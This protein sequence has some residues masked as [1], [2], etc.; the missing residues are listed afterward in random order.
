MMI[1]INAIS[2]GMMIAIASYIYL[3]VGGM[4]GAFLFS[5]GLLT[6]L[7]M[8]F[9]LYTGAIGFIH[10]DPA[11]MQNITTILAGNLIGVCLL[12]FFPHSAAIPLVATKLVLP[13]GLVMIKQ[14]DQVSPS[15]QYEGAVNYTQFGEG[16][17]GTIYYEDGVAKIKDKAGEVYNANSP[18]V[19]NI[20]DVDGNTI[21]LQK[22]NERLT[23]ITKQAFDEI[24]RAHV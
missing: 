6:I 24:G 10:L 14:E 2:G 9:K 3:Q 21:Q 11:D 17:E 22:S 19:K 23:P 13:L 16:R 18:L 12:L 20:K 8:D 7:N 4:V 5:I 15:S 1:L